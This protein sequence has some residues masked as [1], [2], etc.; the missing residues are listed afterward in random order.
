MKALLIAL[1]SVV[2]LASPALAASPDEAA[3][4]LST[5]I[6]S[7]FC[8]GV[9]LHECPSA[10]ALRLRDRIEIWF[11]DGDN[12]EV[13][14][15]RLETE[16]GSGIRSTPSTEGFGLAAW[17]VTIGGVIA[18][19]GVGVILVRRWSPTRGTPAAHPAAVDASDRE[20]L[21]DELSRLRA[22]A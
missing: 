5:E 13:I 11:R 14:L 3:T 19:L 7:P 4:R 12:R 2:A 16:Y 21:D 18:A 15:D 17:L 10:E 9:T 1:A 20:R 22:R 8:P 6:M